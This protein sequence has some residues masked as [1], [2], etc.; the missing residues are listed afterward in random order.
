M[1]IPLDVVVVVAKWCIENDWRMAV[2]FYHVSRKLQKKF[3]IRRAYL[4]A[5]RIMVRDFLLHVTNF[6]SPFH[7]SFHANDCSKRVADCTNENAVKVISFRP[8][9]AQTKE[10]ENYTFY[11]FQG[12]DI[13]NNW[14]RAIAMH[15][16]P[17]NFTLPF[18]IY[19]NTPIRK[20]FPIKYLSWHQTALSS[21][22]NIIY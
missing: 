7:M 11:Y 2:T 3:Y 13:N 16:D 4:I 15:D 21:E 10:F 8:P 20:S 5:R 1:H 22:I 19:F 18:L 12:N 6:T 9:N 17:R 14:S